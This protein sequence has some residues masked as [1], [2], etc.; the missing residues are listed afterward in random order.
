MN[1]RIVLSVALKQGLPT[2]LFCRFSRES[3]S[4]IFFNQN[5]SVSRTLLV[6]EYVT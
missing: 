6:L 3:P 5:T 2:K 4:Y 1:N